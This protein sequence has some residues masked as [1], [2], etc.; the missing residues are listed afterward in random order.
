MRICAGRATGTRSSPSLRGGL[1]MFSLHA[2]GTVKPLCL[3]NKYVLLIDI[4]RFL[5]GSIA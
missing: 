3:R 4:V 1:F 2:L 5:N